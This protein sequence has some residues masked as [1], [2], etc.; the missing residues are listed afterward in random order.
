MAK[1]QNFKFN[2]VVLDM[3][4]VITKTANIHAGAWKQM[5]DD[6]LKEQKGEKFQPLDIERDYNEYIDGKPR[7]DGIRSFLKSRKI[8]LPEGGPTDKAEKNTVHGLAKRKNKIFLE[9]LE[10]DGVE[11]FEDTIEM[12]NFW[13]N[14]GKKLAVISSSRNCEH[15]IEKAGLTAI[16]EIRVDGVVSEEEN[17]KGKPAPDIF[18]TATEKLGTSKELTIVIEDAISGVKAGKK[19]NFALVI[20]VDR[21]GKSES[22]KKAGADIVVKKLTELKKLENEK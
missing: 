18:L 20:G 6:F 16:F 11:V 15:I 7:K 3:D 22:L 8:D 17:L 9:R 14:K 19:G 13:K 12:L 10:K 4:G 1:P 5:F 2:A 21:N